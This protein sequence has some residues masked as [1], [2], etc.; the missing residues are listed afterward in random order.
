MD[1]PQRDPTQAELSAALE[2]MEQQITQ[3]RAAFAERAFSMGCSA[4]TVP[5]LLVFGL[6]YLLGVRSWA[7]MA[8]VLVIETLLVIFLATLYSTRAQ[9]A[10]GRRVYQQTIWPEL[11]AYAA[12]HSLTLE[13]IQAA[14]SSSLPPEAQLPSYLQA[15]LSNPTPPE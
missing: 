9:M 12:Q 5:M 15:T 11:Q 6:I 2:A 3:A 14:A 1:T 13:Q 10:A 8:F 4:L 7:G